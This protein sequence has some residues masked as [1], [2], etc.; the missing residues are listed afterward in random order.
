MDSSRLK[1]ALQAQKIKNECGS[2]SFSRALS[3]YNRNLIFSKNACYASEKYFVAIIVANLALFVTSFL[4]N[5]FYSSLFTQDV[6]F[7]IVSQINSS[8]PLFLLFPWV[9]TTIKNISSNKELDN[10][11]GNAFM[12]KIVGAAVM[13][14]LIPSVSLINIHFLKIIFQ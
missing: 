5:R 3:R 12:G 9:I 6:L 1:S 4:L 7:T 14:S 13:I 11:F 8:L 10:N 2:A